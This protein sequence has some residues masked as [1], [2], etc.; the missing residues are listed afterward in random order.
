M[1]AYS[2]AEQLICNFGPPVMADL[3]IGAALGNIFL[4]DL[5]TDGQLLLHQLSCLFYAIQPALFLRDQFCCIDCHSS[6]D[7]LR[8]TIKVLPGGIGFD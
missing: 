4:L 8:Q 7:V 1:L 6:S 5:D 2:V 3:I